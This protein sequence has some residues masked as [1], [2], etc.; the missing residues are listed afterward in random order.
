MR[1]KTRRYLKAVLLEIVG[2]STRVYRSVTCTLSP[3]TWFKRSIEKREHKDPRV[4]GIETDFCTKDTLVY[5]NHKQSNDRRGERKM[6]GPSKPIQDLSNKESVGEVSLRNLDW[7]RQVQSLQ[8]FQDFPRKTW[9]PGNICVN[10][11]P[12]LTSSAFLLSL[13]YYT[14]RTHQP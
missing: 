11:C 12:L 9:H 13:L 4:K 7:E 8:P 6:E 5:D 10:L 2:C 14:I 3:I 1:N